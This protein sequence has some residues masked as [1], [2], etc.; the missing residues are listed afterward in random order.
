MKFKFLKVAVYN[1]GR[2]I[3]TQFNQV[4]LLA[5][6]R[7]YNAF[8]TSGFYTSKFLCLEH[9]ILISSSYLCLIRSLPAYFQR[10]LYLP[11]HSQ[12]NVTTYLQ[13][14]LDG[15]LGKKK[16]RGGGRITYTLITLVLYLEDYYFLKKQKTHLCCYSIC[17][18]SIHAITYKKSQIILLKKHEL[19]H[20]HTNVT[21]CVR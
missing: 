6:P 18:V 5:D 17:H 1:I 21:K 12:L 3:A 20:T 13:S 19:K 16:K 8:L 2:L 15:H 11:N 7:R 9:A 14:L 4:P 10:I